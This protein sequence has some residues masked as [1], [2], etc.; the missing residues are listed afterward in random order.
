MRKCLEEGKGHPPQTL[1]ITFG[2]EVFRLMNKTVCLCDFPSQYLNLVLK[3]Y[4][5]MISSGERVPYQC[6]IHVK[7]PWKI[8]FEKNIAI[9]TQHQQIKSDLEK[10]GASTHC[11]SVGYECNLWQLTPNIRMLKYDHFYATQDHLIIFS[12]REKFTGHLFY[13][14]DKKFCTDKEN[15]RFILFNR[16]QCM[17]KYP[18]WSTCNLNI[19]QMRELIVNYQNLCIMFFK[20]TDCAII[21]D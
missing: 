6:K 11:Y 14:R 10:K 21:H 20:H 13:L 17:K 1:Q 3:P 8:V 19:T 18:V 7:Q 15:L 4:I 5:L 16:G 2:Q 9:V 12:P